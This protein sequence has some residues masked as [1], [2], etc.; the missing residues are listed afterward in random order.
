MTGVAMAD[1]VA[2]MRD[3]FP[4]LRHTEHCSWWSS[5]TGPVRP[6]HRVYTIRLQYVRRYWIEELEVINGYIPE[7]TLLDPALML[8]HPCTGELVPHVY[9]RDDK[10]ERST[11]CLYDPAA[12]QWSP[13]RLGARI[14]SMPL[15][16]VSRRVLRDP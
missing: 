3:L 10:P 12:N 9:W 15:R 4:A 2:R 16:L 7:V 13:D 5:W 14:K 11:L 6:A 1:Q 8:E